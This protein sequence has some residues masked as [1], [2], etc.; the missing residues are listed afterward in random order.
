M[1]MA[2]N[3][4]GTYS[5]VG[6]IRDKTGADTEYI[7]DKDGA[8]LF[9]KG[10]TR[11]KSGALPLQLDGIGKPLKACNV[12][13]NALQDNTPSADNPVE[14]QAVGDKTANLLNFEDLLNAPEGKLPNADPIFPHILVLHLKPNTTYTCSSNGTG[15][16]K[17]TPADLYRSLYFCGGA[18]EKSVNVNNPVTYT[19]DSTGQVP[20]GFFD[21][22][23]NSQQYLNKTAYVMLNEGETALPYE[24]YGYKIPFTTS[25]EDGS[26]SITT[27]VYLDKPLYK[28]GDYADTLCY[29]EQ[30]AER[31]IGEMV[32]TGDEEWKKSNTY[33]G[34]FY[35]RCL[36][37]LHF[38]FGDAYCS[39]AIQTKAL[40][41][42]TYGKFY[43][44]DNVSG[45][46]LNLFIGQPEWTVD[47]FKAWLKEQYNNGT[48][49]K[50]WRVLQTPETESVEIPEIP[51]LNGTTIIEADTTVQPSEMT[52]K[53]KSRT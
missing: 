37:D 12:S 51:T 2:K 34:S 11:E 22:R 29:A 14:V 45:H 4:D 1:I 32:L 13:G 6:F 3:P 9:E 42:Y 7:K 41:T 18:S 40:S 46:I 17:S 47:N 8:I 50:V 16:T 48:P 38:P 24:P 5:Q 10:F 31:V 53:Y 19:T 33:K 43:L 26:E 23:T 25:T 30:K 15:S 27:T 44:E 21:D 35:A 20:I 39:H 52:I 49:V 28:I 36:A